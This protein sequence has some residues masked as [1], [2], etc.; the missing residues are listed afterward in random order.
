MLL[1]DGQTH[2]WIFLLA[3]YCMLA[4]F[5]NK[6]TISVKLGPR[7]KV[8]LKNNI[9]ENQYQDSDLENLL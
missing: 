3:I 4:K 2:L 7:P 5:E 1:T 9:Q 8:K 6:Q